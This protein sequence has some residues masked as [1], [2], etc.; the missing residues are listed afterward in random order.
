[1]RL[2]GRCPHELDGGRIGPITNGV[3]PNDLGAEVTPK[4]EAQLVAT[5]KLRKRLDDSG[6]AEVKAKKA[7]LLA[8]LDGPLTTF[9]DAG[10]S[11][12]N[13]VKAHNDA[14]LTEVARRDDHRR[15]IDAVFGQI[16]A[17]YPGDRAIHKVI[18]PE[19]DEGRAPS[20]GDG[21]GDG[22]VGGSG[23]STPEPTPTPS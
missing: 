22:D 6:L 12:H 11:L 10:K 7:E 19:V 3:F 9:D 2:A 14:F 4:G 20:D 21:D 1:M 18:V 16:R 15:T 8:V 13:A 23:G 17:A 5:K